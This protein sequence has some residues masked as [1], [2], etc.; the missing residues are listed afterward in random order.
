LGTNH[1]F[2]DNIYQAFGRVIGE[3]DVKHA[4][5]SYAKIYEAATVLPTVAGLLENEFLDAWE[6]EYGASLDGMRAFLDKLEDLCGKPPRILIEVPRSLL[7]STL[8]DGAHIPI[9]KARAT[10]DT[11]T[12]VPRPAW[13]IVFEPFSN[14]DWF[15]W[16]FR[17]RLSV[18][19]RPFI[20]VSTRAAS[21]DVAKWLIS[22][23]RKDGLQT[24]EE[25]GQE[26]FGWYL[27]FEVLGA[28]HTF[29]IGHRP[30]GESEAGTWIGW[31][32]RNRGFIASILGRRKHGIAS[33]AVVAIHTILSRSPQIQD[34]L[35]HY[36]RDFDKG[37]KCV[38]CR[39]RSSTP[40]VG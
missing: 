19:R 23:L 13:R 18:L 39:R 11:L 26:D 25:P 8:A 17:R 7:T 1:D 5:D 2:I 37:M 15:P 34:V 29:I 32:E 21:D 14:K 40:E 4:V 20:Q 36:Q 28:S 10:V 31:L 6:A 24:D 9:E 27:N 35:W 3:Q 16:R 12:L 22:E 33:S 30:S 38:E